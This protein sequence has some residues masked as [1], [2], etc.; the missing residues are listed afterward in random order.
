VRSQRRTVS[1]VVLRAIRPHY[2]P[3]LMLTITRANG[4]STIFSNGQSR[5]A[6]RLCPDFADAHSNLGNA[7]K[8][9]GCLEDAMDCYRTAIALRPEF[10]IAHGNLA[11]CYYDCG[12]MPAA[13]ASFKQAIHLCPDFPDAFNNLGNALREQGHVDD[14]VDCYRAA[15]QLKPDHPHAYN[16]LGE[17]QCMPIS[18]GM[19][20]NV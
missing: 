11:S 20:I 2:R 14:S 8:E 12:D 15:L 3:L 17:Q 10:A 1:S 4:Y 18:T 9:H 16:N 6:L 13:V 19:C 5:E 7:L